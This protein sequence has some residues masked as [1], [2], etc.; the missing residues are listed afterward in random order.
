MSKYKE[1][2]ECVKELGNCYDKLYKRFCEG[3]FCDGCVLNESFGYC[4][5]NELKHLIDK[6][7]EAKL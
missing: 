4:S 1:N 7:E 5:L 3:Q 6:L 2:D